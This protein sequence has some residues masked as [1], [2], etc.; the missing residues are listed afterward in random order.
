M[1]TRITEFISG[2]RYYI[3]LILIAAT[4]ATVA[5]VYFKWSQ[6]RLDDL[7]GQL[8]TQQQ[9]IKILEGGMA[10]LREDAEQVKKDTEELNSGLSEL[11]TEAQEKSRAVLKHDLEAIGSRHPQMLEDRANKATKDLFRRLEEKSRNA[12]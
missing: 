7:S 1:W 3:Y 4:V 2:Y 8:A 12:N 11:R 5:T 6:D 9:Q 10:A